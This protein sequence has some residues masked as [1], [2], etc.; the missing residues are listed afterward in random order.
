MAPAIAQ[1]QVAQAQA[2]FDAVFFTTA[3]W[4]KLD[5]PQPGGL[6]PGLAGNTRR[7]DFAL[8]GGIRKPLSTGGFMTAETNVRRQE[9][10]P[11]FFGTPRFYDS[12]VLVSLTQPLLRN[13][14]SDV[15][16]ASIVLAESAQESE[17][18]R[19]RATLI[20]QV[21]QAERLYWNLVAAK[22][23]LLIQV[24]L[25]E[26]T[27]EDRDRLKKRVTFD[28][29]PVRITEANS[30]VELRRSEV[31]RARQEVRVASD[32]LKRVVNSPELP[33]SDETVLLPVETPVEAPLSFSLLD[34][35]TAALRHR[36]EMQIALLNIKDA[37]VRQRVADNARLP[38]LDL[39]ATTRV[40]GLGL[41]SAGDAY[42][43]L[44][45]ADFIDYLL[46]AQFEMPIGNRA[47]EALYTQRRLEREEA[48][49]DYQR[50]AQDLV[51]AVKSSLRDVLTS[52]ELIGATRASRRA[53]ADS[54][55][56]IEEQEAAGV[57]LTPEFLLD[58]KLS[59]QQRLADAEIQEVQALTG[60]NTAISQLYQAMGTLLD[61]NQIE[62][63]AEPGD[64]RPTIQASSSGSGK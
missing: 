3:D 28:V 26:R 9:Q 30:F 44:T 8:G 58:L 18:Q 37:S 14:G 25:L 12:D 15:N 51:L 2:Q 33:L 5:T 22:D 24:R 45:D 46:G 31:I 63:I 36:P 23:Q 39:T 42:D 16:R 52:Y 48:V 19:L 59:T 50:L 43:Q 47:A 1:T 38:L 13:F 54:L 21:A 4:G 35:V 32:R 60:Y 6:I 61:R 55:R 34:A 64:M 7:E 17:V 10:T 20:D 56:A 27:V 62:F 40:N 53:A 49:L 11:T 29:S 57:A 41:D